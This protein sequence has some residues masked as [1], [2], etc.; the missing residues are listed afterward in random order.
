[1]SR[2]YSVYIMANESRRLYIG[3]TGD[4]IGR[5]SEHKLKLVDGYTKRNNM[6]RLVL[7]EEFSD[8]LVAIEREKELKG[9][10]RARKVALIEATNS[11]WRDLAD[12]WD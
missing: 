2:D 3:V 5:V 8:V 1:M 7:Y 6:T 4:L 11:R 12:D 9:W 10:R